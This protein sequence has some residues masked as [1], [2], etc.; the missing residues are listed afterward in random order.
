MVVWCG[1]FRYR[2]RLPGCSVSVAA[3]CLLGGPAQALGRSLG[4]GAAG[5]VAVPISAAGDT[6]TGAVGLGLTQRA[7]GGAAEEFE[8]VRQA[9]ESASEVDRLHREVAE[10]RRELFLAQREAARAAQERE[11]LRRSHRALRRLAA[12]EQPAGLFSA[13]TPAPVEGEAD[14]VIDDEDG[15]EVIGGFNVT[16]TNTLS[17]G[18]DKFR[19]FGWVGSITL[20][21]LVLTCCCFCTRCWWVCF[22]MATNDDDDDVADYC[23]WGLAQVRFWTWV[24]FFVLILFAF[25]LLITLYDFGILTQVVSQVAMYALVGFIII[26]VLFLVAQEVAQIVHDHSTGIRKEVKL[27]RNF[28]HE[29]KD[30][31]DHLLSLLGQE[32]GSD[33]EVEEGDGTRVKKK[34]RR[35]PLLGWGA[36]S[37]DKAPKDADGGSEELPAGPGGGKATG[38]KG[39]GACCR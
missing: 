4:L 19:E 38:R 27:A 13:A 16:V 3:L 24:Y 23:L 8:F 32:E 39:A 7:A 14:V 2:M 37:G 29:L 28:I 1:S 34:F 12:G 30:K 36:K 26:G 6:G 11:R 20:S 31:V 17:K 15:E 18:L 10:A 9:A 21:F 25:G 35:K 22:T 33:E 5:D